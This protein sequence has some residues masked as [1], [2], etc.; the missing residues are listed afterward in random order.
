MIKI[1][2]VRVKEYYFCD[3]SCPFMCEGSCML[4]GEEKLNKWDVEIY[5]RTNIC[6]KSYI[7]I[8]LVS[9]LY[10]N[11]DSFLSFSEYGTIT[12][13]DFLE[14]V[15]HFEKIEDTDILV[16][17]LKSGKIKPFAATNFLGGVCDDCVCDEMEEEVDG[18]VYFKFDQSNPR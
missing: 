11:E 15:N 8:R 14:F 5:Y 4:S 6:M 18:Y 3:N 1:G 10:A 16:V 9:H 12:L 2:D 13:K 7:P 17:K